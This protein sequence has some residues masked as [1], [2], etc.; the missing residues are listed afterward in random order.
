MP[1]D[2]AQVNLLPASSVPVPVRLSVCLNSI[3]NIS[4]D[5]YSMDFY[6]ELIFTGKSSFIFFLHCIKP[7]L[8]NYSINS[9]NS[10]KHQKSIPPSLPPPVFKMIGFDLISNFKLCLLSC[11]K[12]LSKKV[13]VL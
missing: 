4:T 7:S 3:F 2:Y 1:S 6:D 8:K 11:H 13:K 12:S 9:F 5:T 10:T